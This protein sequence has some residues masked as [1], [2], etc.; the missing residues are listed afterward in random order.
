LMVHTWGPQDLH[1]F[2]TM[3]GWLGIHVKA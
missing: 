2:W 1:I 3:L